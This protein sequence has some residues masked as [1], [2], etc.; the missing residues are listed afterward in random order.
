[1]E[2]YDFINLHVTSHILGFQDSGILVEGIK[3]IK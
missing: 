3:T 2:L 1:M